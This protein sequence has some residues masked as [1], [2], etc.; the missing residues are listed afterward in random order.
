MFIYQDEGEWVEYFT[1]FL[2]MEVNEKGKVDLKVMIKLKVDKILPSSPSDIDLSGDQVPSVT[3]YWRV[4]VVY[5][6]SLV[7]DKN[8]IKARYF[9]SN[10]E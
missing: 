10:S 8:C 9:L 4:R 7:D 3:V 5:F 6:D 2:F 1:G